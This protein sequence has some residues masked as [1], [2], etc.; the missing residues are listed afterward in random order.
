[1]KEAAAVERERARI[2]R[3]MHDEFGSRLTTIANLGELAQYHTPSPADMKSQDIDSYDDASR[4][5]ERSR[6]DLR[7]QR[8]LR[9]P[10]CRATKRNR[11]RQSDETINAGGS[12][13]KQADD[14]LKSHSL[15]PTLRSSGP[16]PLA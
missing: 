14:V 4:T 8:V 2:A 3:D 10:E 12:P 9:C 15:P 6:Q 1:M 11:P 5:P 16:A 13:Q 7:P